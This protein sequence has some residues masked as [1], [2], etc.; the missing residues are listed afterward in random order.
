MV[1]HLCLM[2][3]LLVQP[4]ALELGPVDGKELP[5]ADLDRIQVGDTAPD[6][7]LTDHRGTLYQLSQYRG[8]KK[9]VLV[10]YRGHW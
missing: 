1:L 2:L 10:F 8:Q 5:A 3:G 4:Q 9:V 6:F 7:R